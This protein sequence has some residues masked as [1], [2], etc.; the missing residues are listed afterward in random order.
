MA[1]ALSL[2][3]AKEELHGVHDLP[4]GE[5]DISLCRHKQRQ[6]LYWPKMDKDVDVS[7]G[8]CT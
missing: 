4:R 8:A 7:Q 3:E 1:R 6:R 5:N 2:T